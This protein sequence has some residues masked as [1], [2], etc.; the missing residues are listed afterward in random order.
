[1]KAL[2][3]DIDGVVC[4][5]GKENANE[6]EIFDGAAIELDF[7]KRR[8]LYEECRAGHRA[9]QGLVP[10]ATIGAQG[11]TLLGKDPEQGRSR[12]PLRIRFRS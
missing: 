7:E 3:L 2:F 4:L 11:I 5:H 8:A 10:A 1:M 9:R 6:D 12:T